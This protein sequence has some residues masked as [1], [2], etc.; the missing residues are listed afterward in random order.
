M[1]IL[2]F[3][4]LNLDYTYDVSHFVQA[5]ETL[6]STGMEVFCGG[7]GFNQSLAISKCGQEVWHAGAIGESDGKVLVEA[8]LEAGV[9]I[10]LITT[11]DGS[12]GHAIIQKDMSGQ[13]CILLYGGANQNITREDIDVVLKQFDKGDYLILQNEISEVGYIMEK[14]HEKGMVIVFNPSP[15]TSQI[16]Q[17]PLEY[18]SYLILNEVEAKQICEMQKHLL[19]R[20]EKED[21]SLEEILSKLEKIELESINLEG[22]D[23]E[24]IGK[25]LNILRYYLPQAK[26][27][28]TLGG[29]GAIYIDEE[30]TIYQ[31]AYR[32]KVVDTTAAGD[33]FTGFLIG[34]VVKGEEVAT[35]MSLAAQAAAIAVTRKGAGPSIPTYEEILAFNPI[36]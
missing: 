6:A 30:Q 32:V 2:N 31:R 12:T 18:V 20:K 21:T 17:Y 29:A 22:I 16:E 9:H 1:R 27:I 15:M 5:G 8:L 36:D 4:S 24:E 14:A 23:K 3:G 33:T 10:N 11:K 35:A 34:S 26:I 25:R 28:L 7:K 19:A 13:N